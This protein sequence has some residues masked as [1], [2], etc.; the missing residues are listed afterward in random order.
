MDAT[1]YLVVV[2]DDYGI[3]PETSRAILE[4]AGRGIL[5]G[6]V[7]M[8][9]SPYAADAVAQWRRG[10]APLEL[11][12]HPC[13]T[14]DPPTA[15]AAQVSSLIGPDGSLLPLGSLVPRL[16]SRRIPAAEIETELEAQFDRF[17]ALVG[18]PPTLVNAHQHIS[19]FP[20]VGVLLERLLRRR[21]PTPP[22][23]RRVR[24]TWRTLVRVP[25]ARLK[26]A[27]LNLLGRLQGRRLDQ[28][29]FPG[30]DWLLGVTDPQWVTDAAFWRRWLAAVPGHRVEL[31]CHP[32]HL[33]LT[34][35]GR[36][37][38]SADDPLLQRRVDELRLLSDPDFAAAVRDAGFTVTPP[39]APPIRGGVRHAA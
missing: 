32:G 9:N 10:G 6:T 39:S 17:V 20:P 28:A 25:G 2:A 15:P 3:G 18:H 12:W 38:R 31:C 37:C 30:N 35:V 24:E 4:L 11:G 26:R 21:C 23:V 8:V 16:L 5:T 14:Q 36:D 13:L 1:R 22:Y 34:L 29:G 7:L 33:D 27:T 19:L